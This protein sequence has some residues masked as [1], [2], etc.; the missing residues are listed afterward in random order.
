[1]VAP[2]ALAERRVRYRERQRLLARDLAAEQEHRLAARRRHDRGQ[3]RWGIVAGL[4]LAPTVEAVVVEP[5]V[6]V[7]GYGRSLVV[8]API[9]IPVATVE[10][11]RAGAAAVDIWLLYDQVLATPRQPGHRDCGPGRESRWLEQPSVRLTT[12][13]DANAYSSAR[14]PPEAAP[15]DLPF[16]PERTVPEEREW[17]VYLG[18][19][20]PQASGLYAVDPEERPDAGLVG[21]AIAAPD[22]DA[23]VQ[24]GSERPGDPVRF[25]VA[26]GPR[27]EAL[28]PRLAI[29]RRGAVGLWGDASLR[30]DLVLARQTRAGGR[31]ESGPCAGYRSISAPA[32]ADEPASAVGFRA[33]ATPA[34]APAPWQLYRTPAG[35]PPVDEL[36]VEIGHPGAKGDPAAHRLSIGSVDGEGAFSACLSVAADCSVAVPAG[37]LVLAPGAQLVLAPAEADLADP[38]FAAAVIAQWLDSIARAGVKLDALYA[39]A[40]AL[41]ISG[42]QPAGS[43]GTLQYTVTVRN[44][45]PAQV[46]DIEVTDTAT[47]D[48]AGAAGGTALRLATLDPGAAQSA[49]RRVRVPPN[50]AGKSMRLVANAS[51][52]GPPG[53]PVTASASRDVPIAS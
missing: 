34:A 7:D 20:T 32:S 5:G 41:E 16:G 46:R 25:A 13:G 6:A 47:L 28:T 4:E 24:V 36:R 42:V 33:L 48:G 22:G 3:H 39:G 43:G 49:R 19:L 44:A 52:S 21:E 15:G 10:R 40:L 51:G 2:E 12:L 29:D 1:V 8:R 31:P 17:P 35:D 30:G 18:R 26:L 11:L 14:R 50:S 37:R 53:Y 23:R 27:G 45:G 9:A 38:R